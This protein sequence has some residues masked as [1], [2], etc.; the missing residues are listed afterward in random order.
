LNE[1]LRRHQALRTTFVT[2]DGQPVQVFAPAWVLSLPVVDLGGLDGE[3]EAEARRLSIQEAQRPFDLA[4]GPL[5]RATCLRLGPGEHVLL[6]TMHHIVSDEWSVEVF[7]RELSA[8]YVA[9]S[10]G[11]PASLPDL[12][13][14]YADFA[15]WQREWLE[16]GVQV[17][18]LDYWKRQLGDLS[19][20]L[21]LPADRPQPAA[22]SSRG[23]FLSF[24]F[25]E[26]LH[27]ALKTFSQ[28][29]GVTLF[30]TLLAGF[31]TLLYRYTG[32]TDVV[33]GS[34]VANR[35]RLEIE[36]LIGFFVNTLV[37]R[38]DLSGNPTV[39]ELLGRVRDV[40]LDAYAHQDLPFEMLVQEL[41]PERD[42][43]HTPL[44]Q[45]MF[46]FQN[47]SAG[48]LELSGLEV[49]S[50]EVETGTA[51]FDLMLAVDSA[52]QA[53]GITV[54]YK[55]DRF[56]APTITRMVG[57][58]QTVLEGFVESEGRVDRRLLALPLLTQAEQ[59]LL[60][61]W[62][63]TRTGYPRDQ[64]IHELFEAQVERTPD[65]VALVCPAVGLA[66]HGG[67][68]QHLTYRELNR[69]ANQL[70]H[71]VKKLGVGPETFVGLSIERSAEMVIGMLGVLKAG[72][73]YVPLDPAY[74][75]ERFAFMLE[76][77]QS[78]VLLTQRQLV[79]RFSEHCSVISSVRGGRVICLDSDWELIAQN[80]TLDPNSRT[81]PDNL[82][83]VMYTSGSTGR[84][85]GVSVVHRGVVRLVK[86]TNYASLTAGE[87]FL[88]FAPISFDASTLEIWGSLLN[89]ARLVI[90]DPHTPSLEELGRVLQQQQVTTLWLT[91]GLFHLMVDEQFDN[92]SAIRQ[93]LA[94]GDVL[95]TPHVQ[96]VLQGLEG[97]QMI[98]GYGPTENTTFT[99]CHLVELGAQTRASVPIG[100]PI[101]NTQVYILD[102]YL[103]LVPVGVPGE[104]FVGGDGL[105][106][107]YLNRPAL[108]A[109]AFVPHSFTD[110]PGARLYRTGDLARYL[111]DGKLEFLGRV[112][113]QVKLRGFRIELGEIEAVLRGHPQVQD[114][115]V[116]ARDTTHAP[117]DKQLVAYVVPRDGKTP[118]TSNLRHFLK[119]KLPEYMIPSTFVTLETLPLT[120]N[121]K[122]DRRALP[123]PD[124]FAGE[125]AFVAP[126]TPIEEMLVDVWAQVLGV[127]RLG[128][129][130]DFFALGGHSLLAAQI[131]SR[132]RQLFGG[133]F[134][135]RTL[136]ESPTVA[137]LGA[138]LE[139]GRRG[140]AGEFASPITR[141]S[142][143][144]TLPLSYSQQQLWLVEQLAPGN[145]AYNLPLALRLSG[146]LDVTALHESLNE[147]VRRHEAL[148]TTFP[149]KN[150]RPGQAIVASLLLSL[151]VV[152]VRQWP[153][154]EREAVALRLARTM[155]RQPFDLARGPLVR[156]NL[157]QLD[158]R[159]HLLLITV[160]HIVFDGWSVGVFVTELGALYQAFCVGKPSRQA[161]RKQSPLPELP[162]QYTDYA[163]WQRAQL[164]GDALEKSL[165]YWRRQLLDAPAVMALPTDRPRP[166]IQTF[167]GA[168]KL[169]E[170][171]HSLREKLDLLSW[172]EGV[173]LFMTLLA[174]F[175]TLLY[176]YTG[177][178][179][180][181]VG[182]P[183]AN[184]NRPEIEGL[185]GYF[186]NVLVLRT[187]LADDPTLR[188]LLARVRETTL[189]AHAHQDLPFEKL[190]ETLRP[191]R[192]TSYN[193]LFQV[194]LSWNVSAA[195]P[196]L[197]GLNA[198]RVMIDTGVYQ[199]ADL[200][201][202]LS[203]TPQGLVGALC[204]NIDLFDDAIITRML[205][206]FQTLL[207]KIVATGDAS[208]QTIA[209][210]AS[211]MGWG[212]RQIGEVVP[213]SRDMASFDLKEKI[214][215]SKNELAGLRS[216]LSDAQRARL[217]Q[218][219]R[220]K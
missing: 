132:L 176:G 77:T 9:F 73:A 105:A 103:Q 70:A 167:R 137:A 173:T 65:A 84:P 171:S 198:T 157:F 217:E 184:R 71:Y 100:K 40:T 61:T 43:S 79:E 133:E 141:V 218:R 23:A 19:P 68:I 15:V 85:K 33:V 44:F 63:N 220:G 107:S 45:V 74:P 69:R 160:H 130:D 10:S 138:R 151:P 142:R 134:T 54:E 219:L 34:P 97:C 194:M 25:P 38:T 155:A 72:G 101:S 8:L 156:A 37:L 206:D 88:Q 27:E 113:H 213:T 126:R 162:I 146:P 87:T 215:H 154:D 207:E 135:V 52:E 108:T 203:E 17:T 163:V 200:H 110:Q 21:E 5:V 192:D 190:V 90:F 16:G 22:Q 42:P 91:A 208:G 185:V 26:A 205:K 39:R 170:I 202:E 24:T 147:I 120:P 159:D 181:I 178:T 125:S 127:E 150:R 49:A 129:Y 31:K 51:K 212:Q 148:R 182:T 86:E 112:D 214:A 104:L 58:F 128:V 188:E 118:A 96:K 1:I 158:E 75:Q 201:L 92:L 111:P 46:S 136:F 124:H 122:V 196:V 67:E 114:A 62:N 115:A 145:A 60:A 116:A 36:D 12:P 189:G 6:L 153:E 168:E 3:R 180:V 35:N 121:G 95:S 83:Y 172:R 82:A 89:G 14:Q 210:W 169:F 195:E 209:T 152:D 204:Y 216:K 53:L 32:Q 186:V 28:R 99:T 78:P 144:G 197:P 20:A 149:V 183:V 2:V 50:A 98:N 140:E 117:A 13:V 161:G 187:S 179:D 59:Q 94:G 93:L 76:D 7:H 18:Q 64:C 56:D 106:R 211:E 174:A 80:S 11:E 131:I 55:T 164:Q 119:Q 66:Q 139:A 47:I 41:R 81:T 123:A 29:E 48:T 175:K 166:P 191:E 109:R 30:T 165:A 177:Q 193:P 4:R 199:S 57:H 102:T 143:E